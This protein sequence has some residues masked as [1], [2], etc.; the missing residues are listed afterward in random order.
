MFPRYVFKPGFTEPKLVI[1]EDEL[2]AALQAGWQEAD[3][4]KAASS[5]AE[6]TLVDEVVPEDVIE[7]SPVPW[8]TNTVDE[9]KTKRSRK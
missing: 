2:K 6:T 7:T 1:D 8:A 9:V 5:P 3:D 4:L